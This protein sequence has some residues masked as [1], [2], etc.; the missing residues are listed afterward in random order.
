M[1]KIINFQLAALAVILFTGAA[2]A[3]G[4]LLLASNTPGSQP[5]NV[6]SAELNASATAQFR[7]DVPGY[8]D[9]DAFSSVNDPLYREG[10]KELLKQV[11]KNEADKKS[12]PRDALRDAPISKEARPGAAAPVKIRSS[13]KKPKAGKPLHADPV[14][15]NYT[16]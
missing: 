9:F 14:K 7:T 6:T 4:G 2:R 8:T 13:I 15:V 12:P 10:S 1:S 5:V 11:I 16:F 3:E